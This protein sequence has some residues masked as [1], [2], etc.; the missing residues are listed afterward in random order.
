MPTVRIT[1]DSLELCKSL[2]EQVM[3]WSRGGHEGRRCGRHLTSSVTVT[4]SH[5]GYVNTTEIVQ[6]QLRVSKKLEKRT[7]T[8]DVKDG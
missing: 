1:T 2:L 5:D 6:M 4:V 7:W 8:W 3:G